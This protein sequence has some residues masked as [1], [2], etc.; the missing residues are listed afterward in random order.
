MIVLK[1]KCNNILTIF[2]Y[3]DHVIDIKTIDIYRYVGM[4]NV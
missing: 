2:L 4:T 1:K 3:V